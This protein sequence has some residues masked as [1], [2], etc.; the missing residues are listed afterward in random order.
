MGGV[1]SRCY[2]TPISKAGE[3]GAFSEYYVWPERKLAIFHLASKIYNHNSSVC[4]AV[5]VK[6]HTQ[7]N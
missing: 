3:K 4:V 5:I 1:V 6:P 7:F 2:R